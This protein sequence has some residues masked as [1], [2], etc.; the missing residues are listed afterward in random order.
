M[1]CKVCKGT[2][3]VP[4]GEGIR[5]IKKC[6]NCGGLGEVSIYKNGTCER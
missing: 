1:K 5:G 3:H 6:E 2:G 4:I